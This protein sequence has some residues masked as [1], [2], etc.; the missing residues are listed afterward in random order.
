MDYLMEHEDEI[1]RLEKKT[2]REAVLRQAG[3][4]GIRPGM[5]V[6]DIGCGSGKTTAILK[7]MVG[8]HGTAVGIDGSEERIA[9]ARKYHPEARYI[10]RD[11]TTPLEV[12]GSFDFIWVRFFL[13]Y[14]RAHAGQIVKNLSRVLNPKG[15]LCLIDL[16]YN[17]L[18]HY[19]LPSDLHR[20]LG[21][22]MRHLEGRADFDPYVGRKLYSFLFD[23]GY[24]D[25]RVHM[26]AHH[27]IYGAIDPT[28]EENWKQKLDVAIHSSG[29]PFPELSG[30]FREFRTRMLAFLEDRRR[31]SYTPLILCSGVKPEEGIDT[32]GRPGTA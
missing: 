7:S 23:A 32:S 8:P 18:T 20:A 4:A 26:E 16:D 3:L 27:L 13:E 9:Y 25:I 5:S 11:L 22:C 17:S 2:H 12:T 15:I 6:A 24:R 31:F 10:V 21:G 28:E 14:H 30:G 19:E 29:Y 1:A